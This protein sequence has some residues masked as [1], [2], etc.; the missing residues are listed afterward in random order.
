MTKRI[1]IVAAVVAALASPL[2]AADQSVEKA[3]RYRATAPE[4][5]SPIPAEPVSLGLDSLADFDPFR[6]FAWNESAEQ[7]DELGGYCCFHWNQ[8]AEQVE[9]L[10]PFYWN[11][12][13]E[14]VEE[15]GPFYWNQSAEQ[16]EELG[17]Y[18]WNQNA[19]QVEEIGG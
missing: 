6:A 4:A 18:Y 9:E 1:L 2:V 17:P 19:E 15:L 5:V 11:Q 16:V 13:A 7:I 10:G 12:S 8:N 3:T 14:Q